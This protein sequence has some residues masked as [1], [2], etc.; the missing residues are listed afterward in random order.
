MEGTMAEQHKREGELEGQPRKGG[1]LG[2]VRRHPWGSL[3]GGVA[4]GLLVG[5]EFAV[6]A[7]VG[8]GAA[9]L[10]GRKSGEPL[11]ESLARGARRVKGMAEKLWQAGEE[12]AQ[13]KGPEGKS[14]PSPAGV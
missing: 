10:V 4:A 11:S 9:V 2:F 8:V 5:G 14:G 1:L 6:G 3:A 12:A 7:L 13:G